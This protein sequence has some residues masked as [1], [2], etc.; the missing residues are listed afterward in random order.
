MPGTPSY[1][2]AAIEISLAAGNLLR[3]H[4][5]NRVGFELKS[6]FDLVTEAD[7]ASEKL[8]IERLRRYFPT[9]S[10]QAEEGGGQE[11]GSEYR[12]Y[13][14]PLDGTTNFAHGYPA[15]SVT[16]GLEKNGEMIAGVV[17]D[18]T[19]NELFAAEKGAGA[20]LNGNRVHVSRV[21][22][23]AASLSC[24]GFPNDSR[25]TNPN[26]HFYYQ[27]AMETHGV[28]RGG[29]AAIDMAYTACGR[30]DAFWEIGLKPWDLAAGKLLVTEAGGAF[31]DMHG[32]AHSMKSPTML[33]DNGLVHEELLARFA[34]IF[35]GELRH[36][37]PEIR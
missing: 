24:T 6:E 37:M 2:D 17:F 21:E 30:L 34:A 18:P 16:M 4:F 26:I 31:S 12:W 19:R 1:P 35:R 33:A 22:T 11:I 13:V 15:W 8:I 3:Y 14:D 25:K 32:G 10:I 29:S 23:L 36:P 28:R 5:E 20:Y 7:R 9:H 27:M